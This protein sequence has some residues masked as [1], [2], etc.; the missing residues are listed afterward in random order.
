MNPSIS[1]EAA[2][3]KGPACFGG[4]YAEE[5]RDQVSGKSRAWRDCEA[6]G[7]APAKRASTRGAGWRAVALSWPGMLIP[8]WFLAYL[9]LFFLQHPR[10]CS[11]GSNRK[12]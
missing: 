12:G 4:G 1:G 5:Q 7:L 10:I 3:I 6:P 8:L 2:A 11:L 9:S